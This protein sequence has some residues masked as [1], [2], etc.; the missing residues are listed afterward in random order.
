MD[1]GTITFGTLLNDPFTGHRLTQR[2]RL[3][4]VVAGAVLAE[5]L[6]YSWYAVGEHHFGE[7]DV[8]SAP[9]VVLA[10]VAERTSTITLATG[11]TL[12]ANRDPVLLAEDYATLD[13]LSDGRLQI[14]AG[15]SF[16]EE[17]YAVFDQTLESRP[18]RKREN[19][20]LLLQLWTEER[21][22]WSGRFRPALHEVR[23][24]PRL[25]QPRPPVWVSGGSK[26]DSV[27][28]AVD[29][30]LPM[31]IG[32]TARPPESHAPVFDLYRR[33][34]AERGRPAGLARTGAASHVFVADTTARAREV[35]REYYGNYFAGAKLPAGARKGPFDFD[36][37]VGPGSAICG[38]PAE[39]VDKL[40]RL[41]DLWGHDL[42]LLSIDIGGI[43]HGTVAHA[44]ELVAAEVIPQVA[45]LGGRGATAGV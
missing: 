18:A 15:A 33:L 44:M 42:H 41:H 29:L 8:I 11:T 20:E 12:V 26:P 40:G 35:W 24:Q 37:L 2:E 22:T 17:P 25:L 32:T 13:L 45:G 10:A 4:E 31:V 5:E 16:F 28:L 1:I 38:S 30:G 39:V 6:G 34:W 36:A 3:A 43:P 7:R 19:L 14:I 23:V 9:P 27:H 21:V